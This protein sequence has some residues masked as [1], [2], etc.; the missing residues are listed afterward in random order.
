MRLTYEIKEGKNVVESLLAHD[1]TD[2]E[3]LLGRLKVL[4]S[5]PYFTRLSCFLPVNRMFSAEHVRKYKINRRPMP[6]LA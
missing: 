3:T 5:L 6:V 1:Q 4:F 2:Q